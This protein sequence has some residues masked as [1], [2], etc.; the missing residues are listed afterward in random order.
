MEPA[1]CEN[2]FVPIV[3]LLENFTSGKK[4]PRIWGVQNHGDQAA[5]LIV[6]ELVRSSDG[7]VMLFVSF[8][9]D[10]AQAAD[11]SP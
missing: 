5:F 9:R 3:D 6:C 4:I 11:E 2:F 1:V 8:S 7:V 10:G